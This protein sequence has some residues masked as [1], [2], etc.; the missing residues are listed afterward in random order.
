[1]ANPKDLTKNQ[2]ETL[3]KLLLKQK[4]WEHQ[5]KTIKSAKDKHKNRPKPHDQRVN[6]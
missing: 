2:K 5:K 4:E 1:M 3:K 6:A